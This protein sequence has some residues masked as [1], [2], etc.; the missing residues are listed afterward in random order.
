MRE[1]VLDKARGKWPEILEALGIPQEAL[2]RKH[3]PCPMCGGKDRFRFTDYQSTGAWICNACGTG[4]GAELLKLYH[5]WD[6]AE[7][8]REVESIVGEVKPTFRPSGPDP[9]IRLNEVRKGIVDPVDVIDVP[10]YLDS[11]GLEIPPR[12]KAHPAVAYYDNKEHVGD[13]P[14]M[15]GLVQKGSK[16]LTYHVTYLDNGHKA[17][18][19]PARKILKPVENINGGAIRLYPQASHM[20]VAE[21]IE[22]AI[23]AKMLSGL[24]VWSVL[25]TQGMESWYPPE[26]VDT[27]TIFGDNDAKYGGQKAA[28][29]LAHRLA[30]K[31]FDV[32]VQIPTREGGDF[33][34]ELQ[35]LYGDCAVQNFG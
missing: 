23:A 7:A 1:S 25:S 31:G 17:S 29:S 16:P 34:D 10:A 12:L 3:C 2:T 22:T 27:V 18:L 19:D 6:F 20:G 4:D 35:R 8:A 21:G 32:V 13:Y 9:S 15:L 26:G 24:P 30:C 14:A 28:Y 5:G 11:R 33:N